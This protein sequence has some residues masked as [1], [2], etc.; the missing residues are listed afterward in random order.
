MSS[1]SNEEVCTK[2][3]GAMKVSSEIIDAFERR[4]LDLVQGLFACVVV[5]R[6]ILREMA[7]GNP[8]GAM[9]VAGYIAFEILNAAKD[10]LVEEVGKA[11]G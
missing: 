4:K 10:I 7:K 8:R 1:M 2:L 6:S 11:E 5:V 3:S 9:A